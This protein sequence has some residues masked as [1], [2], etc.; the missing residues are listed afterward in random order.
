[1]HRFQDVR[2]SSVKASASLNAQDIVCTQNMKLEGIYELPVGLVIMN[3]A[4]K[5]HSMAYY[6]YPEYSM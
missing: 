3:I 2:N 6:L 1:M 4:L 5:L